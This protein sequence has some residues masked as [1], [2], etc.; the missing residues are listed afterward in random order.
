MKIA[1]PRLP[2][3]L[4]T[5]DSRV[6]VPEATV[7][8]VRIEGGELA[9]RQLPAVSLDEIKISRLTLAQ[10]KLEKLVVRD[11]IISG[12]DF[13]AV[14]STEIS[15]Q[16]TKLSDIRATGWDVSRGI[17]RDVTFLDCKLDLA[18]FR[19]AR[20]TSVHFKGC[21][22]VGADFLQAHLNK[23]RFED[24]ELDQADFNHATLKDTDLRGSRIAGLRGWQ[25]LRGASIDQTQ[26]ITA[27]SYL[28]AELGLT[29]TD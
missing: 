14:S 27:A 7:E 22:L 18:N 21:V 15:L 28:A 1:A 17:I 10:S 3:H 9:G 25:Y 29:V 5:A 11:S 26:L 6:I 12:C 24:C 20:L 16:R 4:E 23:V 8:R 13:A 2:A 19:F